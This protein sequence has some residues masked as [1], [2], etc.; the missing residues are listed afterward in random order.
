MNTTKSSHICMY[1]WRL[2]PRVSP[3]TSSE[4][5]PRCLSPGLGNRE[6]R[7]KCVMRGAVESEYKKL[8][9]VTTSCL[10]LVPNQLLVS[11]VASK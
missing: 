9:P 8:K 7:L 2:K 6:V 11:L 3:E 4:Q 5:S 1:V 10:D